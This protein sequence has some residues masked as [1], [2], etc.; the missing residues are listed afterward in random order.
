MNLRRIA[1]VARHTLLESIRA[2]L[3]PAVLIAVAASLGMILVIAMI[4]VGAGQ[5]VMADVGTS[6]LQLIIVV[7]TLAVSIS[8]VYKE[9]ELRT[10]FPLLSTPLTRAE[11]LVGKFAGLLMTT[12]SCLLSGFALYYLLV[13][14]SGAGK[15]QMLLLPVPMLLEA[16]VLIA[17]VLFFSSFATPAMTLVFSVALYLLGHTVWGAETLIDY[18][19][20]PATRILVMGFEMAI[21]ALEAF[22]FSERL[23]HGA[24]PGAADWLFA[25]GYGV[26]WCVVLLAGASLIFD[27][28]EI[29]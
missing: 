13:L 24:I 16:A 8:M 15:L 2:K 10:L 14:L 7:Q 5:R 11:Y 1:T 4:S 20:M 19:T 26:L 23:L 12:A 9:Y 3:L 21:P 22:N 28:R 17:A 25:A 6:A 27:R 18:A 29:T